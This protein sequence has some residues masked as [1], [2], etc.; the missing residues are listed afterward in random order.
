MAFKK[1]G[2]LWLKTDRKGRQYLTGGLIFKGSEMRISLYMN[3]KRE[4][5]T[6][7]EWLIYRQ[8]IDRDHRK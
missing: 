7:P 6:D 2:G 5:E 4:Q 8:T 1:I 3:E